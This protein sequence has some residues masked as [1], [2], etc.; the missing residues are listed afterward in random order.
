MSEEISMFEM[1]RNWMVNN[2]KSQLETMESENLRLLGELNEV[3]V[4]NEELENKL[5]TM[6]NNH[7]IEVD[8]LEG[9]LIMSNNAVK[10]EAYLRCVCEEKI[11]D[12]QLIVD[13]GKVQ[14]KQLVKAEGRVV[15]ARGVELNLKTRL[16]EVE[17][18]I[19]EKDGRI[20][21]LEREVIS[22]KD[23]NKC[24]EQLVEPF[25]DQLEAF[26][27]ENKLLEASSASAHVE[28]K[29]LAEQC[30]TTMGHQNHNLQIQRR[31]KLEQENAD[32]KTEVVCLK[33][34]LIR[35]KR[36]VISLDEKL[37][38]A[39]GPSRRDPGVSSNNKEN[40]LLKIQDTTK[41]EVLKTPQRS[42][43]HTSRSPLS[44]VNRN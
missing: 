4:R 29:K 17:I 19:K 37:S 2:I 8:E 30:R 22:Y 42:G 21:E 11:V 27:M 24:L 5:N 3:K 40:A 33:E 31:V 43:R 20:E 41:Q 25:R 32:L 36:N 12:L 44:R 34:Q 6:T 13:E 18:L 15:E 14:K 1:S 39:A 28:I 23:Q 7:K 26:N 35:M 16:Q 38:N 10:S 9:K